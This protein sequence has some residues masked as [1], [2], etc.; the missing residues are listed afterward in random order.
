MLSFPP[1]SLTP[2]LPLLH[3]QHRP[4]SLRPIL[5]FPTLCLP[6]CPPRLPPYSGSWSSENATAP[7]LSSSSSFVDRFRAHRLA[8]RQQQP[9]FHSRSADSSSSS[10]SLSSSSSSSSSI[11]SS[12]SNTPNIG[13]VVLARTQ[14]TSRLDRAGFD[15]MD[16]AMCAR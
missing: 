3:H 9:P 1:P 10:T 4:L 6:S 7:S 16:S 12:Q 15:D 14:P 8:Q 5:T 2:R 13:G 11:D